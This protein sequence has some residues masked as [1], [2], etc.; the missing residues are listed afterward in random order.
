[1]AG[2]II[3]S[4]VKI[5]PFQSEYSSSVSPTWTIVAMVLGWLLVFGLNRWAKSLNAS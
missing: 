4:L 3:G 2:F 5:W 1:M